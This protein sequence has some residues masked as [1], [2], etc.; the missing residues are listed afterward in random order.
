[1]VKPSR[2]PMNLAPWLAVYQRDLTYTA[3]EAR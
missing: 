2:P 3:Q 1:M